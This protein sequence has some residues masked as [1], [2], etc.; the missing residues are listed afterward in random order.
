MM[1]WIV[2]AIAG[3]GLVLEHQLVS[4]GRQLNQII[5]LLETINNREPR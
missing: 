4:L 2:A 3:L 5:N 1:W